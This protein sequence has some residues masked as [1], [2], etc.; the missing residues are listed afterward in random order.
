VPADVAGR[1][2]TCPHCKST[3][4]ESADVCP[5]C[6]HHLRFGAERRARAAETLFRVEGTVQAPPGSP[7]HE[8]E[9]VVALYDERGEEVGRQLVH[10]GALKP[11]ATRRCVVTIE[12]YP[13]TVA[14][15]A[16]RATPSPLRGFRRP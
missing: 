15:E 2:R 11:G 1:T 8:Y 3:I 16:P 14:A 12:G 9:V 13:T 5:K 7:A 4:L 6:R 10:V